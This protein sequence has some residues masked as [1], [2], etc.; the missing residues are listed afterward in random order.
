MQHNLVVE[1]PDDGGDCN[2]VDHGTVE[3]KDLYGYQTGTPRR[4][5]GPQLAIVAR[6]GDAGT[7]SLRAVLRSGEQ[8]PTAPPVCSALPTRSTMTGSKSIRRPGR[9][10]PRLAST[11]CKPA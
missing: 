5:H 4:D 9:R 3:H 6:K 1:A 11:P 8:R 2:Y 7:R 10:E